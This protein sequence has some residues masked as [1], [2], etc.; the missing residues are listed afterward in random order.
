MG[1]TM[2]YR[3]K[4]SSVLGRTAAMAVAAIVAIAASACSGSADKNYDISPIFPLSSDKCA[5][6]NGDGSGEGFSSTCMVT[7]SECERA[8][9]DWRQAMS[10]GGVNDA[11]LFSCD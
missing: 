5:E 2:N 4:R 1:D 6:Y 10:E 8:A 7:K 3:S 9:E 11:I